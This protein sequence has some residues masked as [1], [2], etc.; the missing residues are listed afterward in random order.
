MHCAL[1]TCCVKETLPSG[2]E[3]MAHWSSNA[4][5]SEKH[6]HE[7]K[8]VTSSSD[9]DSWVEVKIP[10]SPVKNTLVIPFLVLVNKHCSIL[11]ITRNFCW[12][13]LPLRSQLLTSS[14]LLF[15][16]V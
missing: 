6:E 3:S 12:E 10:E 2:E 1:W 9:E 14:V 7:T 15:Y 16:Y 13:W 8:S 4:A 5:T 11:T